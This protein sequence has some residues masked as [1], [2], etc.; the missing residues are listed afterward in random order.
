MGLVIGDDGAVGTW[1]ALRFPLGNGGEDRTVDNHNIVWNSGFRTA[2]G[3]GFFRCDALQ[4]SAVYQPYVYFDDPTKT[5]YLNLAT[6]YIVLDQREA[7]ELI[8]ETVVLTGADVFNITAD[9]LT[10]TGQN[11][12]GATGTS[13]IVSIGL[14][15]AF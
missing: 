13:P 3:N 14:L 1:G 2:D 6:T 7:D 10:F 9:Y 5:F 15:T 8:G 12:S 4:L 11:V